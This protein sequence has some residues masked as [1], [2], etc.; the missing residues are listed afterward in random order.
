MCFFPYRNNRPQS[1]SF[2]QGM[3]M[4][5]CG[6]C[7]ECLS[8]KSSKV[9]LAC[10]GEA[11]E[12][13][14][15]CMFTLTYDSYVYD[16]RGRIV[17]E[18]VSDFEVSRR[19]CQLFIKRLRRYVDYH[20]G[21]KIKYYLAAEYGKRTHRAHYHC[22][23]FGW[24]PHDC[25]EYKKSKRGNIIYRSNILE[26]LWKN[27]ICTVDCKGVTPATARYCSKYAAKNQRGAD[28]TFSLRSHYLGLMYLLNNFDGKGYLIEGR[29]YPIPRVVWLHYIRGKYSCLSDDAGK[30]FPGQKFRS[31]NASR[32][33]AAFRDSD[34]VYIEYRRFWEERFKIFDLKRL[35]VFERIRKLPDDKYASYKIKALDVLRRR[36]TQPGYPSPGSK[37]Y[38]S[39]SEHCVWSESKYLLCPG[40]PSARQF[41]GHLRHAPCLYAANDT[42]PKIFVASFS[43]ELI[44]APKKN[45]IS[46]DFP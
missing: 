1:Q 10:V 22:L 24:T 43:D 42:K 8:S 33:F 21:I 45:Q 35:P 18:R 13:V 26:R 38:E 17:G 11:A 41:F 25:V 14:Q 12:H 23:V 27:G 5:N 37:R 7:P 9:A 16:S 15:N 6:S 39:I 4:F 36:L 32:T 29:L 19:D 30:Y 28:D 46:L 40:M 44:F 3:T 34:P 2:R 31:F 20:Y